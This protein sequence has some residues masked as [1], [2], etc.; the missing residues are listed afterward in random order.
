M[1]LA[2]QALHPSP[3][4]TLPVQGGFHGRTYG[5][6]AL[7]TSKTVYRQTFGPLIPGVNI[8]P[9]PNCLHCK[10]RLATPG[11]LGYSVRRLHGRGRCKAMGEAG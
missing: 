2:D 5:A 7:T 4:L 1:R 6:M 10:A 3:P 8:A 11:G 9:Y